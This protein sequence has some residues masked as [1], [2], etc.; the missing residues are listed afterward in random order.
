MPRTITYAYKHFAI[1]LPANHMLPTYQ[2][3]HRLYDRFL[4]HLAKYL[5]RGAIVIDVGANCGDSLASMFDV[6]QNLNYVCIE[7][8]DIFFEFLN[9]NVSQIKAFDPR[10]SILTIKSLIGKTVTNATLEGSGG[11]K[12]AVPGSSQGLPTQTLDAIFANTTTAKIRLLKSDV[13]G[14]DYDVIESAR[15]MIERDAPL[16]FFECQ[17]D[18]EFQKNNYGSTLAGL[19]SI[20]YSEWAVFDNFG[21]L[22]LRT[23]R[24]S[25]VLQLFDYVWRQNINQS[26]RTIYYWDVLAST[27]ADAS[28]VNRVLSDYGN[29]RY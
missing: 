9:H 12:H 7:P 2:K 14:Y 15:S 8:D 29:V 22:V 20:G 27:R 25:H 16:I 10:A 6:N 23:D 26:T 17:F 11:T 5:E 3:Q 1:A 18:H 28:L 21:G 13:D 19:E 4:P 24:V